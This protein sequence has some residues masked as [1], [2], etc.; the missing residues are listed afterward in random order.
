MTQ[1]DENDLTDEELR[2]MWS[3]GEPAMLSDPPASPT[4]AD[5]K[6]WPKQRPKPAGTPASSKPPR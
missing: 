3:K 1:P 5:T 4:A 2:E 6:G